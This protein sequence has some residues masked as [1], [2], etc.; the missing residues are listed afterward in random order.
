MKIFSVLSQIYIVFSLLICVTQFAHANEKLKLARENCPIKVSHEKTSS[1]SGFNCELDEYAVGAKSSWMILETQNLVMFGLNQKAPPGKF[2]SFSGQRKT[3]TKTF[4]SRFP[5]IE[6]N[7]KSIKAY[8]SSNKTAY[9]ATGEK[10][11][12]YLIKLERQQN[13]IGFAIPGGAKAPK[14]TG[15]GGGSQQMKALL[16][17]DLTENL[18]PDKIKTIV[19]TVSFSPM[20]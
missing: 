7:W 8:P 13:C 5:Y 4:L 1:V 17:C 19:E 9:L 20:R 11:V 12:L 15:G 14:I 18:E 2:Y 3:D 16:I 6:D 10:V